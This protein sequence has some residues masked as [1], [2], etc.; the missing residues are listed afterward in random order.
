MG[1]VVVRQCNL[2]SFGEIRAFAAWLKD[3][4]YEVDYMVLNAAIKGTP[5]WCVA[6]VLATIHVD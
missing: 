4:P 3:Q 2:A 5:K 6:P 1:E